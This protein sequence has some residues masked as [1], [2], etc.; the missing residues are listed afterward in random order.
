MGETMEQFARTADTQQVG[1]L[2][3]PGLRHLANQSAEQLGWREN[4][5][6]LLACGCWHM[7]TRLNRDSQPRPRGDVLGTP[8]CVSAQT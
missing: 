8:S 3:S 1:E 4:K 2:A 6:R 5:R 7:P